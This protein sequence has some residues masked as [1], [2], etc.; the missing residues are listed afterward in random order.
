VHLPSLKFVNDI[1]WSFDVSS[2]HFLS[3][4]VFYRIICC[5][6]CVHALIIFI[7]VCFIL[8]SASKSPLYLQSDM[9]SKFDVF[10]A[11]KIQVKVLWVVIP[12][13]FAVGYHHFG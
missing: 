8:F 7:V 4:S 13:I 3:S 1:L 6:T 10:T 11:V 2:V 9:L 12:C 5:V